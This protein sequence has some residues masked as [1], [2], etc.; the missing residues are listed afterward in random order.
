MYPLA[1]IA[2]VKAR[3]IFHL[4]AIKLQSCLET[5]K[6]TSLSHNM[7]VTPFFIFNKHA[8]SSWKFFSLSHFQRY[9]CALET[10]GLGAERSRQTRWSG[11]LC[12]T[13]THR[14]T[15]GFHF[16]ASNPDA[17]GLHYALTP[18][19]CLPCWVQ[20]IRQ[21]ASPL[22][23]LQ[24]FILLYVMVMV[25]HLL[26][27]NLCLHMR[28]KRACLLLT[29]LC[30]CSPRTDGR[31]WSLASLPSSGYGTNTP[32]STVSVSILSLYM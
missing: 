13:Y 18:W 9:K 28:K 3:Y 17:F 1:I 27:T 4:C 12:G 32:S 22:L 26:G 20:F 31:R 8:I 10:N 25:L 15:A 7:A 23:R 11:S 24:P 21:S 2:R 5:I 19:L 29:S 16:N 30:L 14:V 6:V